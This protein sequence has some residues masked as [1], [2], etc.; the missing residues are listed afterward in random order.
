VRTDD[1]GSFHFANLRAGTL[2]VTVQATGFRPRTVRVDTEP[3]VTQRIAIEL[4]PAKRPVGK[5]RVR[6]LEV[7]IADEATFLVESTGEQLTLEQCIGR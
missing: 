5:I 3:D 1:D 7:T 6:G 4:Q 2:Q